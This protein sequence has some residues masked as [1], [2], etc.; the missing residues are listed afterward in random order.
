M[1]DQ[2]GVDVGLSTWRTMVAAG[3]GT[4]LSWVALRYG[5]DVSPETLGLVIAVAVAIGTGVYHTV[6]TW[7]QRRWPAVQRRWPRGSKFLVWAFWL[8]LGSLRQPIYRQAQPGERIVAM[9]PD[10]G[11]RYL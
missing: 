6:A 7:V 8:W 1:S 3:A 11:I 2:D 4:V 10:G 9:K 5:L